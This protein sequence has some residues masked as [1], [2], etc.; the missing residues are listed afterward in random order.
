MVSSIEYYDMSSRVR[1]HFIAVFVSPETV[2]SPE[3]K[4]L[5]CDPVTKKRVV[6]VAVDEAHCIAEWLISL[7]PCH[8]VE[9][10]CHII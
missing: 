7:V 4:A 5:M 3:W 2:Q 1:M 8:A 9:L 6:M 10:V